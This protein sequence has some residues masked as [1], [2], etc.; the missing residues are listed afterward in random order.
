VLPQQQI[1]FLH[2]SQNAGFSL[3]AEKYVHTSLFFAHSL[4]KTSI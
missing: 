2:T 1:A 4:Q 3:A